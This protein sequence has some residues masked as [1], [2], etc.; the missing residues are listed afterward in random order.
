MA[1]TCGRRPRERV[2]A[3]AREGRHV[4]CGLAYG[5]PTGR[6][7]PWLGIGGGN[8]NALPHPII[9]THLCPMF[10]P[11]GTMFP[12]DFYVLGDVATWLASDLSGSHRSRGPES[13][14]SA[15]NARA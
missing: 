14:R 2:H 13:M 4:A 8:A 15:I 7:G 11:C 3:N 1:L 5:G 12:H 10:S 9:L 6:V